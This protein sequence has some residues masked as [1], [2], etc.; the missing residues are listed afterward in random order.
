MGLDASMKDETK[1]Q[2]KERGLR[3]AVLRGDMEAWR[4]LYDQCFDALFAFIDFR[5]GRRR[6][7]TEEAVQEVWMVAVRRIADFDPGRASFETWMRGIA[8]N[9]IRNQRRAWSRSEE[10]LPPDAVTRESHD[11][12]LSE[13][14]GMALTAL[15]S[16]YRSVLREKYED[17]RSV[18]EIARRWKETPKAVESLLTRARSAFREVFT[19]LDKEQ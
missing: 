16:R 4:V 2:W 10:D 9:V 3:D 7:R 1:D 18:K 17:R 5:T 8:A 15:P 19:G 14:V 12:E 13:Q 11:P 6:D